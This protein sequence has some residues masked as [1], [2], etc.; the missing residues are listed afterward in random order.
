MKE[1]NAQ[2]VSKYLNEN[3][4]EAYVYYNYSGRGMFGKSTTAIATGSP[5][6]VTLAMNV[7]GIDDTQRSDSLGYDTIVY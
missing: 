1:E 4:I 5:G 6:A 3:G 2:R 7:L